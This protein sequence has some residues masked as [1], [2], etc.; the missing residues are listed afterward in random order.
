MVD[1]REVLGVDQEE[2][3][4]AHSKPKNRLDSDNTLD[5]T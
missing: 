3:V 5:L 4:M 1:V 2:L